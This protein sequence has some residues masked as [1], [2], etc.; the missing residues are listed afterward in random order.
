MSHLNV[1]NYQQSLFLN[2]TIMQRLQHLS[3]CIQKIGK[4]LMAVHD[5]LPISDESAERE[6]IR[7]TEFAARFT[8][9]YLYRIHRQVSAI[10]LFYKKLNVN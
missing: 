10:C 3:E 7:N 5:R 1:Q 8:R 2:S 6:L 9:N 4:S